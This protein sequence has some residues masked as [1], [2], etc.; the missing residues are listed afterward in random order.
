MI[1][2]YGAVFEVENNANLLSYCKEVLIHVCIYFT[3]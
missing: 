3:I 2:G 1:K